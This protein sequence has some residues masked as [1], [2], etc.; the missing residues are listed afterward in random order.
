[1]KSQAKTTVYYNS[2]CPVCDAGI[3]AQQRRMASC[4]IAW[5]DVHENPQAV[6]ALGSD[7][8]SVRQRLHVRDASGTVHVG[9]P[10]LTQLWL[11]TPG[12]M[13]LGRFSQWPLINW[14]S[15]TAYNLFAKALYR[16]NRWKNHW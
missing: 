16:W 10:A 8:E 3:R 11:R 14:F 6:S 15:G 12:Q 1:M 7:L 5:V 13:W 9:A 2:A 4:D